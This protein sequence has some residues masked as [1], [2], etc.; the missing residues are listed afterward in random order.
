MKKFIYLTMI[1]L[2]FAG[3]VPAHVLASATSQSLQTAAKT[4][5][6]TADILNIR[7]GSGLQYAVI[8]KIA[9]GS[10]VT[11]LGKEAEWY[12]VRLSDGKIGWAIADYLSIEPD[13]SVDLSQP[14]AGISAITKPY[15]HLKFNGTE[16]NFPDAKPYIDENSRAQVPVR[17]LAESM[18]FDVKWEENGNKNTITLS[19]GNL[20]VHLKIGDKFAVVNGLQQSLD[21]SAVLLHERTYVPLRF[22]CELVGE[23]IKWDSDNNTVAVSDKTSKDDTQTGE[24]PILSVPRATVQQAKAWAKS[25]GAT[26]VFI[27][28]ADIVWSEAPKAGV[29]PA[30][31]YCQSAKETGFGKFGGVLDETFKNPAGLKKYAGGSDTDQAAHQSF[32]SWQEG[33]QAQ[34]DHLA[35]YAGAPGYPKTRTSDPRHFPNLKGIAISVE[36][37]G[38]KWAGS[39]SYGAEIVKMVTEVGLVRSSTAQLS[40]NFIWIWKLQNLVDQYGG[41]D[42]LI[43]KL[44]S[45]GITNV[46]IKFH[47][48]S[49]P[50]GKAANYKDVFFKYAS[51]FKNAG[52][53]VGTWGFNY[54]TDIQAEANL[55]NE[56]LDHSDY[57][58]F[59]VEEKVAGMTNEA[60]KICELV[61]RKHP[62]SIIGYSS[63]PIVSNHSN[64]PY[65]VFNKYCNFASPQCYWAEMKRSVGSC[66]DGMIEEYKKYGLDKP[67][68]PTIQSYDTDMSGYSLYTKYNFGVTGVWSF[69][70]MDSNFERF[71]KSMKK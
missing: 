17:F 69:D 26:D 59:D 9:V 68:Y 46:C 30:V 45:L 60:I 58:I 55:I 7:S 15:F 12:R 28:L 16:V 21:T 56:A 52:F 18:N 54:F 64:I 8:A 1:F 19:K 48:G 49:S 65:Q 20:K 39:P 36:A 10:K 57:Y 4:A 38:G 62:Q 11:I 14:D 35:L 63:F 31:V 24:T 32:T 47:E 43:V 53:T 51:N 34:I 41:I 27:A 42:N 25:K 13:S 71:A 3:I 5:A 37:L 40:N 44:K 29:D 2:L 22:L 66:M 23:G 67:I 50:N 61:R 70:S 33:V 6:V